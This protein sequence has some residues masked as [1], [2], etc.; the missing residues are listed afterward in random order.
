MSLIFDIYKR[1]T[2]WF[3]DDPSRGIYLEEFVE[4]VPDL[5]IELAEDP[6][7][8]RI[9]LEVST[10]PITKANGALHRI[11]EE[12]TLQSEGVFYSMGSLKG[13]F[14][15]TFWKYFDKAPDTLWVRVLSK[16]TL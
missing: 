14:C 3:F 7:V 13:W 2:R 11:T 6:K 9:Q 8:T 5:I 4:G 10:I 12:D 1:D 16:E 15:P